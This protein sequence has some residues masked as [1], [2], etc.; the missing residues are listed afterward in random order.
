[1]NSL[2][3]ANISDIDIDLD[4]NHSDKSSDILDDRALKSNQYTSYYI[5]K[6]FAEDCFDVPEVP[7]VHWSIY[8]QGIQ[9]LLNQRGHK[10][11]KNQ[12]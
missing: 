9:N 11:Q 1:M 3:E 4:D 6:N 5:Q 10:F 12:K 2:L 8:R 7:F